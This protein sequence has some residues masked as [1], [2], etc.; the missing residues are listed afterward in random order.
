VGEPLAF[1]DEGQGPVVGLSMGG[2]EPALAHPERIWALGLIATTAE[3]VTDAERRRDRGSVRGELLGCLSSGVDCA[4]HEVGDQ[5][6][7]G[8]GVAGEELV[9]RAAEPGV[10]A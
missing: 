1:D 8:V 9:H 6:E 4:A 7:L 3:P 5:V 10:E 2:L